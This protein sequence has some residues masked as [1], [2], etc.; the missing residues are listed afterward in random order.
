MLLELGLW[1]TLDAVS[2]REIGLRAPLVADVEELGGVV[3]EEAVWKDAEV[4][5][6]VARGLDV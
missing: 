1:E 4:V 5:R 6:R 2:G 3:G